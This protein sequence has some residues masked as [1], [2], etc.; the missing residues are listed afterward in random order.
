MNTQ[1]CELLRY[2]TVKIVTPSGGGTGFFVA[3]DQILTCA[4][5]VEGLQNKAVRV[6]WQNQDI[7]ATVTI[8]ATR[9]DLALLKLSLIP[10]PNLPPCV[11]Y[12]DRDYNAWDDFYIYGYPDNYPDGAS[13]T[14]ECEG[15]AQKNNAPFIKFKEGQI[16]P[17]FSGAPILNRRTGKVCG[18]VKFTRDRTTDLGGG[19]VPTA[20]ILEQ[21]IEVGELNRRHHQQNPQW[22]VLSPLQPVEIVQLNFDRF[23]KV[24]D[25]SAKIFVGRESALEEL[26]RLLQG[27]DLVVITEENNE[28]GV[29][30]TELAIQYCQQYGNHYTGGTC[31]FPFTS[32]SDMVAS[33]INLTAFNFPN[34]NISPS[35][36][37]YSMQTDLCWKQWLKTQSLRNG[38]VLVIFDSINSLK[39]V[40]DYLPL[41]STSFKVLIST[42]NRQSINN[43]PCVSLGDLPFEASLELL[44]SLTEITEQ[45]EDFQ[46]LRKFIE[47]Y[48]FTPLSLRL[49]ANSI[50]KT[51][52]NED[53]SY[54]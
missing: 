35:L 40:E 20:V 15:I 10:D 36:T 52:Q 34:F 46:I 17:G 53:Q 22:E 24:P 9:H 11:V 14:V 33:L 18:I 7:S 3:P 6:H 48:K 43:L 8:E 47:R 41:K 5:V 13:V 12:L 50:L 44:L 51:K 2:C 27:S 31:W 26:H 49:I 4:H 54:D 29:G 38:S 37:N 25:S 28:G 19:A 30:K 23:G 21:F 16:R 45:D 1:L 32:I 42:R 39:D